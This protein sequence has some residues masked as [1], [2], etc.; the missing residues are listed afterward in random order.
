MNL[1]EVYFTGSSPGMILHNSANSYP[2]LPEEG[3]H[4]NE[5]HSEEHSQHI[6]SFTTAL[7]LETKG[8]VIH[9]LFSVTA[10]QSCRNTSPSPLKIHMAL[11]PHST[12]YQLLV[13]VV[14]WGLGN[15]DSSIHKF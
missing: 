3:M 11:V 2:Y 7:L 15:T 10:F 12:G 13:L 6:I 8:R 4:I 14:W 1:F 9:V 5:E